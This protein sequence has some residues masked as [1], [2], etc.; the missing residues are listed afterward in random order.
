MIYINGLKKFKTYHL[1]ANI[2]LKIYRLIKIPVDELD[3]HFI[4]YKK[5][6]LIIIFYNFLIHCNL[7]RS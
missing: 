1:K 7:H 5:L 3:V 6:R 2:L 4:Q